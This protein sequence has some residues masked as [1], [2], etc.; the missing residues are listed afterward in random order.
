M[1]NVKE[2][3]RDI[4]KKISRRKVYDH[5]HSQFDNSSE[6]EIIKNQ[7]NSGTRR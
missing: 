3:L 5:T 6:E 7:N 4:K 2:L 1:K